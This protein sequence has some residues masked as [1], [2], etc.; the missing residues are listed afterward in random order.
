MIINFII[1]RDNQGISYYTS[2]G[3]SQTILPAEAME[4]RNPYPFGIDPVNIHIICAYNISVHITF[5]DLATS[6]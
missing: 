3:G 2:A 4:D 5:S 6:R 1:C